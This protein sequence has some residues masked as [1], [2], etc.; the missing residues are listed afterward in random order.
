[1]IVKYKNIK[2]RKFISID[3]DVAKNNANSIE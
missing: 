1:M 3:K 2:P